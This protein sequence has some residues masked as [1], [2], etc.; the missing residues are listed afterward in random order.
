MAKPA[1]YFWDR[2][3]MLMEERGLSATSLSQQVGGAGN[4]ELVRQIRLRHEQKPGA[5]ANGKTLDKIAKFFDV[6]A[7]W[8][9]N[10]GP[11][12]GHYAPLEGELLTHAVKLGIRR[13][14]VEAV[15]AEYPDVEDPWPAIAIMV[16]QESA[17]R[18]GLVSPTKSQ[19]K[20]R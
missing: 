20:A 10:G 3:Q 15:L 6:S 5:M 2:L 13:E 18:S 14:I 1:E 4:R 16:A 9:V 17:A 8:L 19:K 12:R 11:D 7:R